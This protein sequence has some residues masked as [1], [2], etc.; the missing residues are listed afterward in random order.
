MIELEEVAETARDKE[1]GSSSRTMPMKDFFAWLT[2]PST[3][4]TVQ[5]ISDDYD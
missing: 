1:A 4:L 3:I 2:S 5:E